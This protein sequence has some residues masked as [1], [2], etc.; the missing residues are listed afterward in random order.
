MALLT[1][2]GKIKGQ[3]T[4]LCNF[5]IS[6]NGGPFVE[7]DSIVLDQYIFNVPDSGTKIT[8]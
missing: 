6:V 1:V 4:T 3:S 8:I 7:P 2:T 5:N